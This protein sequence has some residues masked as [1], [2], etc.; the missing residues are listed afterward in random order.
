MATPLLV[1]S[2][3]PGKFH[4]PALN[5]D[6]ELTQV[7]QGEFYDSVQ[8]T[9]VTPTRGTELVLM[10]DLTNK[11]IQH[12][13]LGA[14][15]KIPA[16][17]ELV[18]QKLGTYVR[19]ADGGAATLNDLDVMYI[20]NICAVQF[21]INERKVAEGPLAHFGMGFGVY[22]STTRN[23]TGIASIGMPSP[24]AYPGMVVPQPVGDNDQLTGS[25]FFK[26]NQWLTSTTMP[27]FTNMPVISWILQGLVKSPVAA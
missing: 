26:D 8:T 4:I 23:N 19:Q 2:K 10:R 5:Q 20:A 24:A 25:I 22:G 12:N 17:N 7:R 27:T 11:N 9:T 15:Y 6:V 14:P 16:N 18:I 3:V 21:R 13:N 1:P